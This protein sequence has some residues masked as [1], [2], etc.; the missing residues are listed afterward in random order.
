MHSV[1]PDAPVLMLLCI[2]TAGIVNAIGFE[3]NCASDV[4][5]LMGRASV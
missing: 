1:P 5:F 3:E 4:V 2:V